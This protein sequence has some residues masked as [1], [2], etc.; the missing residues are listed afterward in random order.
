[1]NELSIEMHERARKIQSLVLQRLAQVKQVNIAKRA[2]VSE[3]TVS[4]FQSEQLETIASIL[5]A[6]GLKVVSMDD[7]VMNIEEKRFLM[8]IAR[9]HLDTELAREEIIRAQY[10]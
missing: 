5:A 10:E 2:K 9:D 1:M 3:S 4:R 6:A 8:K 7:Q